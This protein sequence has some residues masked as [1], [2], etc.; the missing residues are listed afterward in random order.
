MTEKQEEIKRLEMKIKEIYQLN[1]TY[2]NEIDT[3]KLQLLNKD[4]E[5]NVELSERCS[6]LKELSLL[7]SYAA[8]VKSI[9]CA[10]KFLAD[11]G[12]FSLKKNNILGLVQLLEHIHIIVEQL[13]Q[14]NKN[15]ID[16][17]NNLKLITNNFN[18]QMN[19][20]KKE[21]NDLFP[22]DE[23]LSSITGDKT[24]SLYIVI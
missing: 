21:N 2:T 16:E 5:L 24:F 12:Y 10:I 22:N 15:L 18:I 6:L 11:E 7:R 1:N 13:E 9:P 17:N 23:R 4:Q 8:E 3:L 20:T 14:K 19:N